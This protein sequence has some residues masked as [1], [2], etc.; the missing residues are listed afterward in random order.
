MHVVRSP[1]RLKDFVVRSHPH[2]LLVLMLVLAE[3]SLLVITISHEFRCFLLN[4]V[5]V[6]ESTT[7]TEATK[8]PRG[9]A[10]MQEEISALQANNTWIAVDLPANKK[11]I[12]CKWVFQVKYNSD[13]T[14]ECYKA[15]L[16]AKGFT[17]IEGDDFTEIFSC[18]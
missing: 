13:G 4:I 2:L 12:C 7:Y 3:R 18:G 15:R 1:G 6:Q 16:V 8:D 11:P 10:A 9:V 14:I 5:K 17:Q